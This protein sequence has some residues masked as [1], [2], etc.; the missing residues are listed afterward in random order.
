VPLGGLAGVRHSM[1]PALS[2]NPTQEQVEAWI[3]LAQLTTDA[4]FRA[5]V[6]TLVQDH[7]ADGHSGL[8]P[9]RRD[10]IAITRDLVEPV[11]ASGISPDSPLAD[12]VVAAL[13]AAC[14]VGIGRPNDPDLQQWLVHRL[15]ATNDPR[16][17]R[18]FHL[19]AIINGWS[20]PAPLTP[21]I[22]WSIEALSTRTAA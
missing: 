8:T 14:E 13:V 10:V 15:E 6:R 9:P 2:D 18:Y 16:R 17:D 5:A 21:V 12:P 4:E 11:M 1:T 22:E 3:E 19:L 7:L 20:T